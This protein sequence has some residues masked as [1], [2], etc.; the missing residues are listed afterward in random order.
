[1]FSHLNLGTSVGP[2][3]YPIKV[4]YMLVHSCEGGLA[5]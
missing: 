1:M 2:G 4:N 3:V 5:R